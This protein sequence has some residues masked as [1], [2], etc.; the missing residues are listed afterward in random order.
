MDSKS[1]LPAGKVPGQLLER[2]LRTYRTSPDD[3]VVVD[4]SYGFD[5]AAISLGGE[6]LLVKSDP[7][8]FATTDAATYLVAVNA[9]DIAC[10]GGIPRWMTVVA[11]LPEGSTTPESIE[12]QFADLQRA[13]EYEGVSLIGGHTE[14][15]P[16]IDRPLLIGTMLGTVGPSGFLEPGKAAAGHELWLTHSAGI[17]G[18]AL[19]AHEKNA[20]L[21]TAVGDDIVTQAQSLLIEPGISV[22]DDAQALLRTGV[23]SALHDPTEGG[24]AT[25]IHEIA[26]ASGLGAE[27]DGGAIPILA[28]TQAITSHFGMNPLG[29]LSSG[30]LLIATPPGSE[31]LINSTLVPV[32]RVGV[33][34]DTPESLTISTTGGIEDLPRF[35]SDEFTRAFVD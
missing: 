14:I 5:A 7:I 23:I 22:S 6:T 35:D 9:N 18:T 2:L 3:S 4:A 8:T 17:E 1:V 34:T 13:C 21:R 32:A 26:A 27:I 30:C 31:M 10:M 25:A 16:G 33:L 11:L 29:L 19:L 24:V 20:E 15:T 28:C 12:Q